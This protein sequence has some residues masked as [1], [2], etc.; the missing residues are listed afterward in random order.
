MNRDMLVNFDGILKNYP[1]QLRCKISGLDLE[2]FEGHLVARRSHPGD[3]RQTWRYKDC[4]IVN[5]ETGRAIT[6]TGDDESN[7]AVKMKE[8]K[9]KNIDQHWLIMSAGFI[10]KKGIPSLMITSGAGDDLPYHMGV[11]FRHASNIGA[12]KQMFDTVFLF[13]KELPKTLPTTLPIALPLENAKKEL[14][15]EGRQWIWDY[16][17]NYKA[18]TVGFSM[19]GIVLCLFSIVFMLSAK[20]AYNNFRA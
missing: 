5:G 7:L 11:K 3:T 12:Q 16:W 4:A 6:L 2:D 20:S 10:A 18:T 14:D 8:Y 1:F 9:P 17:N 19:F 13:P 15:M